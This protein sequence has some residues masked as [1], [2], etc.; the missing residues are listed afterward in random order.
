MTDHYI[1]ICIEML[2]FIRIFSTTSISDLT[3]DRCS[4]CLRQK[5]LRSS[6][7]TSARHS[8]LICLGHFCIGRHSYT[9]FINLISF[10]LS[11]PLTLKV[12]LLFLYYYS[13]SIC[14]IHDGKILSLGHLIAQRKV[15]QSF[16]F[17]KKYTAFML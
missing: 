14:M 12:L 11:S 9:M 4:K 5:I 7:E 16:V 17:L 13:T 1:H 3:F 2:S 10:Y 8:L 15:M 6:T